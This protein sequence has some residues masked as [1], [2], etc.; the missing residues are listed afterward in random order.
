MGT[1]TVFRSRFREMI[2]PIPS[3]YH[4]NHDGWLGLLIA[5]VADLVFL[6]AALVLYRQHPSQ[7]VGA[8][9][10]L[11]IRNGIAGLLMPGAR[12]S[13]RGYVWV[14]QGLEELHDRLALHGARHPGARTAAARLGD[15]LDHDRVRHSMPKQ[16]M[17]RLPTVLAELATWR[18]H[19]Y[20]RGM[21]S[22]AKDLVA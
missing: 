16:R 10:P 8:G 4:R 19:R 5:A 21:L 17:A 13:P 2:L 12:I 20:S 3:H 9:D 18:Y 1:T 11:P 22:A 7:Q 15:R 14:T 6:E